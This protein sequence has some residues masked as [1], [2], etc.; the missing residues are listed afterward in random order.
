VDVSELVKSAQCDC[1]H[2]VTRRDTRVHPSINLKANKTRWY[3]TV[4]KNGQGDTIQQPT[5]FELPKA[6]TVGT[7]HISVSRDANDNVWVEF[8]PD[9]GPRGL[10]NVLGNRAEVLVRVMDETEAQELIAAEIRATAPPCRADLPK[11]GFR[12][13]ILELS[14]I[15]LVL[16]RLQE[17]N[18]PWT[19]PA[20]LPA[21]LVQSW[22]P[23]VKGID[24]PYK[25][26]KR[27]SKN[28]LALLQAYTRVAADQSPSDKDRVI[29]SQLI[30]ATRKLPDLNV[31]HAPEPLTPAEIMYPDSAK[32]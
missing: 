27:L 5:V 23:N 24:A 10:W 20:P 21:R 30:A 16:Q 29:A 6:S 22:N 26:T 8:A 14:K 32:K 4:V 12:A 9:V 19:P 18:L 3:V 11:A 28:R 2:F 1:G 17:L 13:P 7:S 31:A 15:F 25:A